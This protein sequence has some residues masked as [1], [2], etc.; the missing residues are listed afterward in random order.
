MAAKI[1]GVEALAPC[2][3]IFQ[4]VMLFADDFIFFGNKNIRG[5]NA[6]KCRSRH[7]WDY[8]RLVQSA[9]KVENLKRTVIEAN[10]IL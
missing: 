5:E 9:L 4:N 8:V 2:F 3:R 1:L 6:L 10:A 7:S